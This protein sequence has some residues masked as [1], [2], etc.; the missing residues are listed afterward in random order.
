MSINDNDN[1]IWSG[2]L[3]KN[4]TQAYDFVK[5]NPT[6]DGRG[7]IVGILDTGVDPGAIGLSTTTD[8]K[9]KVIDV[10]DCSGSGDVLMSA[11]VKC[12]AE[13]YISTFGD[14]QLKINKEWVNP[15]GEFRTGIKRVSD[16]LPRDLKPR[17]KEERKKE[18][19]KE[20]RTAE[21]ALQKFLIE[22]TTNSTPS[23]TTGNDAVEDAKTRIQLLKACEKDLDEPGPVYDCIVFHDGT[24]WQA[25]V[26]TTGTGDF[27]NAVVMTDY[28]IHLQYSKFSQ[29]DN[30]NYC[31]NIFDE[32]SI[33]SIVVDAGAHGSHVA[34]IV[35][36][37]HPDQPECNGVAP[38]AQI[39][40]LKIGDSRLGSMETGVGLT[41]ALIEAVKLGCHIINMS[42]G[43][44]T[45]I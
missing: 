33:L 38:G 9:P 11:P 8:G 5:N 17:L 32:G 3:P 36:A 23:T 10:I 27:T 12:T 45:I 35:A 43:G 22:T 37:H 30:C 44:N 2:L 13:G 20:F 41:R 14:R 15:S 42:Y 40:S 7:I 31:V 19:E 34:G 21:I 25:A 26:D 28:H 24:H 1:N 29:S 6:F 39:I 4:E 18:L 16:L